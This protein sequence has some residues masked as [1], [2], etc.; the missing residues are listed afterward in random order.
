MFADGSIPRQLTDQPDYKYT[1][2]SWHPNGRQ[3]A[4]MRFNTTLIIDPPELWLLGL[5]GE[6]LR[7]VI[8]GF[9][10]QWIP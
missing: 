2:F 9:S 4:T 3:V 6:A 1:A 7:L 8:G 10:P 5:D